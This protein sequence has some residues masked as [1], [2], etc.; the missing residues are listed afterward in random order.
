VENLLGTD[1]TRIIAKRV[2]RHWQT[3]ARQRKALGIP[4]YRERHGYAAALG[5]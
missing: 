3:V 4:S 2:G 1:L 5:R